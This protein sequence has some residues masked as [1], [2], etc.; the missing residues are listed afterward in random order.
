MAAWIP[1]GPGRLLLLGTW[2]RSSDLASKPARLKSDARRVCM[3]TMFTDERTGRPGWGGMSACFMEFSR[4]WKKL[5]G[6]PENSK[7]RTG[8]SS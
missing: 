3:P 2:V 6:A 5:F 1:M 4:R 8:F 7:K